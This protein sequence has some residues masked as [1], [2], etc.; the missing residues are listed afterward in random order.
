M[1]EACNKII[2]ATEPRFDVEQ[3]YL[4]DPLA[5]GDYVGPY[6]YLYGTKGSENWRAVLSIIDF[7]KWGTATFLGW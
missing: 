1:R 7:A 6:I 5:E 4:S 2:H 3:P